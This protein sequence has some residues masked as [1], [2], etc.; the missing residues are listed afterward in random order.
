MVRIRMGRRCASWRHWPSTSANS[1]AL[2]PWT[3][4]SKPT[5]ASWDLVTACIIILTNFERVVP[6][7]AASVASLL[8]TTECAIVDVKEKKAGGGGHDHDM[9]Y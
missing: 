3:P 9:D 5:G 4:S 2:S 7:N 8:L 6:S 1:V